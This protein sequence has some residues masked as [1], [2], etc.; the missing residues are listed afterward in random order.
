MFCSQKNYKGVSQ[1]QVLAYILWAC[2]TIFLLHLGEEDCVTR[3]K[4][5]YTQ[6]ATQIQTKSP[7][8][9]AGHLI[10]LI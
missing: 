5:V 7:S 2:H 1:I 9:C 8:L 3:L 4:S 10:Y 6:E